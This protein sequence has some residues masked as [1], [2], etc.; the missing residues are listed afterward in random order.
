MNSGTL[1]AT[2]AGPLL[3][4]AVP[5]GALS[6]V[7]LGLAWFAWRSQQRR[8]ALLAG[9]GAAF[10]LACAVQLRTHGASLGPIRIEPF[11]GALL[12]GLA[13][14][15]WVVTRL[16][17]AAALPERHGFEA[18]FGACLGAL[19][20]ARA[21]YVLQS[22]ARESFL[23][24]LALGSGGLSGVG[25]LVGASLGA[26]AAL[27]LRGQPV[28]PW[29]DVGAVGALLAAATTRLGSRLGAL[30]HPAELYEAL[31]LLFVCLCCVLLRKHQRRHGVIFVVAV[32]GYALVQLASNRFEQVPL[33][34]QPI[35]SVASTMS[36]IQTSTS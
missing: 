24:A 23:E 18:L 25:A 22:P 14:G 30:R 5:F 27:R 29:L 31:G 20:G 28:M 34:L 4:L 8:A 10:A 19:L 26:A 12:F 1:I 7:A 21:G 17:R 32:L 33:Q 13:L 11:G 6:I 2:P 35:G 36:S 9:V 3:P 16:S 15:I